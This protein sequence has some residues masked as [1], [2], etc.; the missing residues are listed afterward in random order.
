MTRFALL[1]AAL[2]VLSVNLP[3][4]RTGNFPSIGRIVRDDPRLDAL[5]APDARI[6]VLATGFEWTEGP[7]WIR[8]GG[9]LL[10]SDIPRNSIMK[11]TEKDGAVLF[12]KPSGYT[13][14]TDYG[15][16]PGT[17]GLTLDSRGRI[18]ACEHGDRR[19][20]RLEKDGG[21]R[22]L[23]D[24]YQGKRLNSP[25]DAVYKS[26]GDLY[27][28]DPPYGLPK[29]AD[30][31]RRELDFCGV[32][33]YSAEGK[34]TLLTKE[35]TRPN[36]IAFSPDEKTLYVAQ[37]DPERA[38]WMAFPVNPDGLLGKGRLLADATAMVGKLPGLPDGMKVDARGNLF[39]TG[40]GGVHILTPDGK[41]LGRIETGEKTANCAWGGDGSTLY[42][43]ADMYI[44]RIRTKTRG[45]GWK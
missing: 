26:N 41:R 40:P 30:D 31:P 42:I 10:F 4:Q 37:S 18:V 32:Y 6:E 16:E 23:V 19:I 24:S 35:M 36:G 21:K 22:T 3:A 29:G 14:V 38:I 2:C 9:H 44:C 34:L 25:N 39:A 1:L 17:N 20:S 45:A 33:R 5:L 13:G 15:R 8:E 12:M 28:T 11:W 7:L 27:F 43:T